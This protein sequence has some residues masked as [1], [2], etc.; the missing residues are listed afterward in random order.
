M[1]ADFMNSGRMHTQIGM[2]FL[3]AKSITPRLPNLNSTSPSNHKACVFSRNLIRRMHELR[4]FGLRC[5]TRQKVLT[6]VL[7]L[8][9]LANRAEAA[10]RSSNYRATVPKSTARNR[11][12]LW[13]LSYL[14]GVI[15]LAK[16]AS[17]IRSKMLRKKDL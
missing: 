10:F 8:F 12:R 15:S 9:L 16:A 5:R 1:P 14:R 13:M 7:M 6:K 11:R 17:V 3:D 4:N 2:V